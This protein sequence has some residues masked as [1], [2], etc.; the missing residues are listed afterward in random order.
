MRWAR[1]VARMGAKRNTYRILVVHSEGKRTLGR[2]RRRWVYNIKM[3]L[4][5]IG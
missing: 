2:P 3:D 4:R 1:H 5:E